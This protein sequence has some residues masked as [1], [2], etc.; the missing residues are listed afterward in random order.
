MISIA[1]NIVLCLSFMC[2]VNYKG[3]LNVFSVCLLLFYIFVLI[4]SFFLFV[5]GS[6]YAQ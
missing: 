5:F 4:G 1:I 3:R 6:I 2:Y